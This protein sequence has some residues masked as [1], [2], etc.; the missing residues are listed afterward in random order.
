MD[1]FPLFKVIIPLGS[2]GDMYSL[3]TMGPLE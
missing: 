1:F 3:H 2:E